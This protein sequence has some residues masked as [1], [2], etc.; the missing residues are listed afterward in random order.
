[1]TLGSCSLLLGEIVPI[2][3]AAGLIYVYYPSLIN[4]KA[5]FY[6]LSSPFVQQYTNSAV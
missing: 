4:S 3:F 5:D 2:N 6:F 1:M